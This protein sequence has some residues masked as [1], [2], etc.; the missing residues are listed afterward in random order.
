METKELYEKLM[1]LLKKFKES[2]IPEDSKFVILGYLVHAIRE[3]HGCLMEEI[4]EIEK[5]IL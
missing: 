4:Q 1:E 5:E 3:T 2:P